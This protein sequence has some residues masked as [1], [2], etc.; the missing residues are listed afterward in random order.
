MQSESVH[1]EK[2]WPGLTIET[3]D[4]ESYAQE[5]RTHLDSNERM[6]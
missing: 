6:E 2:T 3:V 1:R 5:E 4:R